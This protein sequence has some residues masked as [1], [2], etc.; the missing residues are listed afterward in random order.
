MNHCPIYSEALCNIYKYVFTSPCRLQVRKKDYNL[1]KKIKHL[2]TFGHC[3]SSL[4]TYY[5][6]RTNE[7]LFCV[8]ETYIRCYANTC[9]LFNLLA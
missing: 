5:C 8:S 7:A 6:K 1:E 4:Y 2:N 9:V 3:K